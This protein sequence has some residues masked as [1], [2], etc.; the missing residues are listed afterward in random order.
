M[1]NGTS[2]ALTTARSTTYAPVQIGPAPSEGRATA[3]RCSE[4]TL[5]Y[6]AKSRSNV[7]L[8]PDVQRE[9]HAC[10][11][12][13]GVDQDEKNETPTRINMSEFRTSPLWCA[14]RDSNP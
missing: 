13:P 2:A 8:D 1:D 3:M 14:T 7:I 11:E 4:A 10:T 12:P 5:L 9:A 6:I